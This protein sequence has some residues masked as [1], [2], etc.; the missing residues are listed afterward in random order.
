MLVPRVPVAGRREADP[1]GRPAPPAD[2]V[3][4]SQSFRQA[5]ATWSTALIGAA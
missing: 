3:D 2:C 4:S 1:A 5:S